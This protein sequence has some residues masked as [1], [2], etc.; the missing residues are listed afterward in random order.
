MSLELRKEVKS[1]FVVEGSCPVLT[2]LLH[3]F[4]ALTASYLE[5]CGFADALQ[6][7]LLGTVNHLLVKQSEE[8]LISDKAWIAMEVT[9][10]NCLYM[11][12]RGMST[13]ALI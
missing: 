2:I 1:A 13:R 12:R 4:E 11:K 6:F 10:H 9:E 3:G 5:F 7:L 8:R